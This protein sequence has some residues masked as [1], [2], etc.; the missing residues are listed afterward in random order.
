MS[1][2]E[3]T[4]PLAL[5]GFLLVLPIIVLYLLRPKPKHVRFPS[6][7]FII[8]AEKAKRLRSFLKKIVR[9]P[10]LLLQILLVAVLVCAAAGP[11]FFAQEE[12]NEKE[13]AVVVLDSSASMQATDVSPD[14]FSRAVAL[15]RDLISR[16]NDESTVSIVLSESAPIILERGM[17]RDAAL[18]ALSSAFVSDSPSNIGDS[19]LF[20]KDMF[21]DADVNK[22]IYVLSDYAH[23]EGSDLMLVQKMASQ[24]NVSVSFI[25]VNSDGKNIGIVDAKVKRYVTDRNRFYVT[26]TVHN[27]FD[28]EKDVQA[29]VLVDGKLAATLK[30][31]V[32]GASEKL[33]TYDGNVSEDAHW[34]TLQL[35]VQDSLSVDNTAYL[36]MPP[37]SKYKVLLITDEVKT[38]GEVTDQYLRYALE[39]SKDIELTTKI[40]PLFTSDFSGYDVVILG[41]LNSEFLPVTFLELH[42]Y[43]D[44]GGHVIVLASQN[45]PN[46]KNNKDLNGLMPFVSLGDIINKTS[47]IEVVKDQPE[48]SQT[49]F[50]QGRVSF[51]ISLWTVISW[52]RI[53]L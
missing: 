22:K 45:L 36:Y 21:S 16:M 27:Y 17:K 52:P 38:G 3:L 44:S 20:A 39:S 7:M 32:A 6:V 18:S 5:L 48:S 30:Q 10:L 24:S 40:P 31:T 50:P 26:F 19:V 49:L 12:Q 1:L 43:A 4:A 53:R 42:Q 33:F 13:T 8:N 47:E 9:D 11:Y 35:S 34:V 29:S 14:R 15:A 46:Y 25:R 2:I 41:D 28:G 37:V 23:P 51:R